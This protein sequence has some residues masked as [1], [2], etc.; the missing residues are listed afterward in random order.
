[1]TQT[2]V[3]H[4]EPVTT[5][6]PQRI[7]SSGPAPTVAVSSVPDMASFHQ[8]L[9]RGTQDARDAEQQRLQALQSAPLVDWFEQECHQRGITLREAAAELGVTYGYLHQL[10]TGIRCTS[11]MSTDLLRTVARFLRVPAILVRVVAGDIAMADFSWPHQS[12]ED[13]LDRAFERMQADP[14]TR[15]M[16]PVNLSDLPVQA[17]RSLVMLWSEV[18]GADVLQAHRL[19]QVL[20]YVQRCGLLHDEFMS[21]LVRSGDEN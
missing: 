18:S 17:R 19:P 16:L 4:I 3:T 10:R 7:R 20:E 11:N 15:S 12:E 21:D 6:R 13:V 1:M 2:F 9:A 14:V 8:A 5:P